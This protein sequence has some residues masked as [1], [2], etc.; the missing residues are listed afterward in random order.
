MAPVTL[1]PSFYNSFWSPDYRSGLEVLFKNLEQGCLENEDVTAF[2][3]SQARGHRSLASTLLNP[4]LPS[5]S[6]ESS[7]SLSHTLLSLR[8]ASSARGEAHLT[9][10]QELEER[11]LLAWKAWMD[12]HGIRIKEA[13]AE[14]LGKSGVI[15][16]WEKDAHKLEQL[17]KAYLT[18]TRAA[19]DAEDDAKFAPA[20]S[21]S[22]PLDN[23]TSS[24]KLPQA[25]LSGANLRRTATVADRIT[26]KLRGASIS[27]G[28]SAPGTSP[29]KHSNAISVD[30]KVLPPPPSPL[31]TEDLVGGG[32][33]DSPGSPREERFI[34]PTDPHGKPTLPGVEPTTH[35]L[36]SS[37]DP[38]V[39]PILLSGLSLTPRGLK[40]ILQRLDTHLLTTV[41]PNAE[42][43]TTS[44]TKSNPALASRQRSTILG[45]Y[46]KTVSGA[47]IVTW[48]ADNVEAF[49][50]DWERCADA[51]G[52]LHKMGYFSRIGV[53]RGF[54]AGD[55][56]YFILKVNGPEAVSN[57]S[58]ALPTPLAPSTATNAI[59]NIF[60]QYQ[61]YL[62]A[63][64]A[65]SDEPPH[66][67][68]RRDAH[69]ADEMYREGVWSA[70]E[71]R[72]EMEERIE[73]GLRLWERWERERLSAV[74]TVL[75]QYE[76][77]LAKLPGKL[78]NF[79]K[80]TE[81]SV[82]AFNP[83]ADIKALIE[84]NRTGPFR[85][86]SHVYESV[87]TDVP[88]VN[89]GI[90]L[91][92]WSGERGWKS[93]VHAPKREK[94]AIPEALEALMGA[95]VEMYEGI[96]EEERRRAWIYEVPLMETHMLRNAINN[97]KIPVDDLVS[98]VKKFNAPV[99]AGT[100]KLYLLELNP[101]VMG[102]EGWEDAKA[103]YPAVG[104]DQDVDMTS[105]VA[106]VLGRLPGSHIFALDA[107]IKHFRTLIDTTKS[108]EPDEVYITKL[109]L[110]VGRTI[111]RPQF[112]TDLTIGDR[113]PSLFLADLIRHYTA[114]FPP[115]VEKLKAETD[116]PMPV[117]KRTAL[118]DQRVSRSSLGK[119]VDPQ[120]LL[121][122][123]RAQMRA[124]SPASKGGKDLPPIQQPQVVPTTPSPAPALAATA[125]SAAN[126]VSALGFGPAIETK[127]GEEEAGSDEDEPFI[128]PS[129]T[130]PN[131]STPT[132]PLASH[133][134][135]VHSVHSVRATRS[136]GKT[137]LAPV[138]TSRTTSPISPAATSV[139][140]D[141]KQV[142]ESEHGP[143]RADGDIVIS[144][145]GSAA[146]LKRGVSG[147]SSR[148][149][150]PRAAR[151]PRPAPGRAAA[152][153]P[154]T[155]VSER[156]ES[157]QSITS[158][159]GQGEVLGRVKSRPTSVHAGA[160]GGA[161]AGA[162]TSRPSTPAAGERPTSRYGNHA[163]GGGHGKRGSVSA[164]AAKFEK[165]DE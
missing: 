12:R 141:T 127:K 104:A 116:R 122:L 80:S 163:T 130:Q 89:F 92:R 63:S 114:L 108:A 55:D 58:F 56:T 48:L 154:S 46:E 24:P 50:G 152:H 41:A 131:T 51:A 28:S 110:S 91:R 61:S 158:S 111:L 66:V 146:G 38:N 119:D 151:G 2:I 45:T 160:G 81:L 73:R 87:D 33:L 120:H 14:M 6:T 101:P 32:S 71:K 65:N 155:S 112:E 150:G 76:T 123:Q 99:A 54:D 13:K 147:E 64:L 139:S 97:P 148:L 74:K 67:R 5:T 60:K 29:S 107:V 132:P 86:Q 21:R 57:Q 62:P 3:E 133:Q 18:K 124:T 70:E 95:L 37:P 59:P 35:E 138:A 85:P 72:L 135:S 19:D 11:V 16:V 68:L 43:P 44:S 140:K 153:G 164:M 1:P 52:E 161:G 27:S 42:P 8:G 75:K 25:K 149:R 126:P 15:G 106:S 96:S 77:T 137:D 134:S 39:A 157:P 109:A 84:G 125:D 23:Y 102:W 143:G 94:G 113:T 22:P 118:V 105:A 9:L 7:S 90:D 31:K 100:I 26:E 40:E 36:P 129:D 93:L 17:K 20:T 121:E 115:L 88:D 136:E 83:E 144:S 34:P 53:G 98:I 162:E 117:K 49:G 78:A 4:P 69:K 128:P 82:E 10:A 47:E 156:P 142:Q 79:Q 159:V 30:G 103:V 145:G 165:R